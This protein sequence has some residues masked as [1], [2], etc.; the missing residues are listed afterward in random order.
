V[1]ARIG[2]AQLP[3][4]ESSGSVPIL[5][6]LKRCETTTQKGCT[7][8]KQSL[9]NKN[10]YGNR[11]FEPNTSTGA[12]NA[13]VKLGQVSASEIGGDFVQGRRSLMSIV[14]LIVIILVQK[15]NDAVDSLGAEMSGRG[16]REHH[17]H[18]RIPNV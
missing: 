17:G 13:R 10:E 6:R 11:M 4:S 14:M 2:T 1:A 3:T 9:P 12:A 16:P 15:A 7:A 5:V 18:V 8:R